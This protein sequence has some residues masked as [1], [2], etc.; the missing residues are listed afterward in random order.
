MTIFWIGLFILSLMV[1]VKGA[2]WFLASSEKFGL[3][4]GLSK[5]VVG[6][7]IVGIGTS[8]PELFSSIIAV[9]S[10]APEIVA[11]NAVGSNVANILL[12]V[13]ISV[14]MAGKLVTT[15][16][17]I[18][19]DIPL[20]VIST[21][22]FLISAWDAVITYGEAFLLLLTFVF[23]LFYTLKE[24]RKEYAKEEKNTKKTIFTGKD[25]GLMVAGLLGLIFGSKYLIE[26][27][28]SLSDLMNISTGAISLAAVAVGT[29]LPELVVSVKAALKGKSEVALGNI[30]GSNVFNLMVVV[31]LP[32][33]FTHIPLDTATYAIGLPFL[34]IATVLF[35]ISGISQRM[36]VWEGSMY[37]IVYV[38]FIGKLFSLF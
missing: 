35:T 19:I 30:F 27:V 14:V 33:L 13:G 36:Y 34:I 6:V 23:Y 15:K 37:I 17:L 21:T 24:G 8:L 20:L 1:L 22:L 10:G 16:Y 25:T 4:K 26:S 38:F 12:I 32:A 9:L 7:V 2:D 29:S 28:I 11:A 5:F 18:D 3:A 31:G